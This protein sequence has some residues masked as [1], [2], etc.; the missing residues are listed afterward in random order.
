MTRRLVQT[1]GI[2][3]YTSCSLG[4]VVFLPVSSEVSQ[5]ISSDAGPL[6][7]AIVEIVETE[8]RRLIRV[9][10]PID[11]TSGGMVTLG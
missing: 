2:L 8:G 9:Y 11:K 1:A 6:P 4:V 5:T 10:T 7:L 3:T